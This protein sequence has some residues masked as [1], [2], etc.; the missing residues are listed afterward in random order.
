MSVSQHQRHEPFCPPSCSPLHVLRNDYPTHSSRER[1]QSGR[2]CFVRGTTLCCSVWILR[3]KCWDEEGRLYFHRPDADVTPGTERC[4]GVPDRS[5][6]CWNL[7]FCEGVMRSK[8][9][10]EDK[11][12]KRWGLWAYCHILLSYCEL[13]VFRWIRSVKSCADSWTWIL[14]RPLYPYSF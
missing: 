1:K 3:D 5:G 2:C 11:E 13:V 9:V 10:L 4:R 12:R 6:V 7:E 8:S 14:Y